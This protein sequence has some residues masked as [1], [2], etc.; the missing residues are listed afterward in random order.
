MSRVMIE[1]SLPV[2][3]VYTKARGGQCAYKG[4]VLTLPNNVQAISNVLSIIPEDLP[5]IVFIKQ[6]G[7]SLINKLLYYTRI[8]LLGPIGIKRKTNLKRSFY[9]RGVPTIFFTLSCAEFHWPEFHS[10]FSDTNSKVH[11]NSLNNPYIVYWLFTVRTEKFVKK[12]YYESLEHHGIGIGMNSL[13]KGSIHCD[14]V[15]KLSNDPGLCDLSQTAWNDHL[16][17]HKLIDSNDLMPA[18]TK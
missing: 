13:Y 6:N 15:A 2:M 3:H 7:S 16:A 4:H 11:K 8:V 12:W 17:K 10:L 14:G 9:I 5:V 1:C 18:V